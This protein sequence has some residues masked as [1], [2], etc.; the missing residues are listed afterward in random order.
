MRLIAA[1]QIDHKAASLMLY[2]LQIATTN[3]QKTSFEPAQTTADSSPGLRPR[4]E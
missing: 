1:G 3:L 4:S 2:S